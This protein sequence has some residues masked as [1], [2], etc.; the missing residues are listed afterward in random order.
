M[1]PPALGTVA[2]AL[3][4]ATPGGYMYCKAEGWGNRHCPGIVNAYE[5]VA[6]R[7]QHYVFT[8]EW[9]LPTEIWS[10]KEHIRWELRVRALTKE[11]MVPPSY[12]LADW[13]KDLV[14]IPPSEPGELIVWKPRRTGLPWELAHTLCP[15]NGSS[16][17]YDSVYDST[18]PQPEP[19]VP[20]STKTTRADTRY[21]ARHPGLRFWRDI[22]SRWSSVL[23]V[24]HIGVLATLG[25]VMRSIYGSMASPRTMPSNRQQARSA[26]RS[27]LVLCPV[28]DHALIG[29]PSPL[30]AYDL[31]NWTPR[32]AKLAQRTSV[33]VFHDT[34][35]PRSMTVMETRSSV[36]ANRGPCTM[37]SD[38][39]ETQDAGL[40]TLYGAKKLLRRQAPGVSVLGLWKRRAQRHEELRALRD[41]MGEEVALRHAQEGL[42]VF[43]ANLRSMMG[44]GEQVIQ[45]VNGIIPPGHGLLV[46]TYTFFSSP[47]LIFV[48]LW[49]RD[50][51][52]VHDMSFIAQCLSA[53]GIPLVPSLG[54]HLSSGLGPGRSAFPVTG[55]GL[56][57]PS[58]SARGLVTSHGLVL[59][60][61]FCGSIMDSGS[62]IVSS[63]FLPIV[64]WIFILVVLAAPR[65][66]C[67]VM[68][69]F[70]HDFSGSMYRE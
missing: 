60:Y 6:N 19:P 17:V 42:E 63:P 31:V 21:L 49:I 9:G 36:V 2:L 3:A 11:L 26:R 23:R 70:S 13:T 8:G 51:L 52:R 16:P 10:L 59:D 66:V 4:S 47:I 12:E 33:T 44:F 7:V 45:A 64:Y 50:A 38:V 32:P 28:R 48:V 5:R 61:P 55:S 25:F 18:A 37:A 27:R 1:V 15:P 40:M 39:E 58:G 29:G 43:R 68:P 41:E 69:Y 14:V 30:V 62:E 34:R 53:C 20:A 65:S 46:P 56:G 57:I 67:R 35:F 24:G 22:Q 54:S